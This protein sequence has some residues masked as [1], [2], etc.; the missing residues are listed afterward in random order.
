VPRPRRPHL[1][2]AVALA[3][4]VAALVAAE[5]AASSCGGT[6]TSA[7]TKQVNPKGRPPLALGDSVMLLALPDLAKHGYHANAR[8]CR[9]WYQGVAMLH[10]RRAHNRLPHLV[11]MALGSNGPVTGDDI[12]AALAAVPKNRVLALVTPRDYHGASGDG[13][14]KMRAAAR[15]H[16]HRILLLDWLRYSSHHRGHRGWFGPDGLHLTYTGAKAYARFLG[17]AIPF[18]KNGKFPNGAHFPR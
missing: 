2:V 14:A 16:K 11:T 15:R 6:E 9:Q 13:A 1:L 3:I 18:A 7:P 12:R 5:S 4:V 10:Q 8:G 17:K